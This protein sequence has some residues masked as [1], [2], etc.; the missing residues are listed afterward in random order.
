MTFRLICTVNPRDVLKNDMNG[1]KS[2]LTSFVEAILNVA[3]AEITK[4][5]Q[6]YNTV[7]FLIRSE[8]MPDRTVYV[9]AAKK[10][11]ESLKVKEADITIVT[12]NDIADGG[13][14]GGEKEIEDTTVKEN[15]VI[16]EIDELMS[17]LFTDSNEDEE[18][19]GDEEDKSEDGTED[20]SEDG[21]D[22]DGKKGS[23]EYDA[24]VDMVG[25]DEIKAW[26]S[27]INHITPDANNARALLAAVTGMSYLLA[28]DPGNGCSSI[29][30][31]MGDML[32]SKLSKIAEIREVTPEPDEKREWE[33]FEKS[34]RPTF[35]PGGSS[36]FYVLGIHMDHYLSKTGAEQ[37]TKILRSLKKTENQ[38]V[39][40]IVPFLEDAELK[41]IRNNI[42]DV[43]PC[44][45][46]RV[47][48]FSEN[49][50]LCLFDKTIGGYGMKLSE[51]CKDL[52]L[53]KIS[54]EKSDG[55][56]Y[57]IET[58]KKICE[59][60]LYEKFA[61][62]RASDTVTKEDVEAILP[63]EH[64][65]DELSGAEQLDRLIALKDVKARI[66]EICATIT[67]EKQH[68][69][70]A[71]RSMHMIFSGSPG[72]GKTAVARIVGK[73]LKETGV[74]KRGEFYEVS[75]KDLVG[76]YVGHT[77]PKTANACRMAYGSVL[78]IDEAYALAN[79]SERDFGPEA[80]STLIAEMENN[81]S[82]LI[83]IFAGYENELQKLFEMNPGLR[84]RIPYHLY[85]PNYSREELK[86]IFFT[87]IP[88]SFR[89]DDDFRRSAEEYF[90]NLSDEIVND[91]HFSNARFVRNIAERVISKATLRLADVEGEEAN[92]LA[93]SDFE[94][95]VSDAEFKGLS[96]KKHTAR[97]G[98]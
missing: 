96:K 92:E 72:T 52:L 36:K 90:A 46:L 94:L 27:Q 7:S 64:K 43:I 56:F 33:E 3:P 93:V 44:R 19:F 70:D 17:S 18:I 65:S 20:Q 88:G 87:M 69:P 47:R 45:L 49:E 24:I 16:K 14:D 9:E 26:A 38:V 76:S 8:K 50:F 5:N 79:G 6:T 74:L 1:G 78:F 77:A 86:E 97:I 58:V 57:G 11:A 23:P 83:V 82:R 32:A 10:V 42:D 59:E 37:F 2:L 15:P 40:F 35:F 30:Q 21:E 25:I 95:A 98:F 60:I 71:R 89:Y 80:I 34:I 31:R 85:F 28:I 61:Q 29:L 13:A 63:D 81:R 62:G 53:K 39:V 75:R 41:K 4:E 91:D 84:D 48:P 67:W 73:M 22:E 55:R 51:D 12:A 66:K 54:Y 68:T